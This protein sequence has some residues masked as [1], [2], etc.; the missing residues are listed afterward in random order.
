MTTAIDR[1]SHKEDIVA[2]AP[3]A[4]L[5]AVLLSALGHQ[6]PA[7]ELPRNLYADVSVPPPTDADRL[8]R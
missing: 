6:R 5:Y 7:Q 8:H 4:T 2:I 3:R 1:V